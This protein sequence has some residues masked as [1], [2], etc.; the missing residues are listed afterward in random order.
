MRIDGY[1]DARSEISHH[2]P[3]SRQG[4]VA[5]DV[6]IERIGTPHSTVSQQAEQVTTRHSRSNDVKIERIGTSHTTVS[7]QAEQVRIDTGERATQKDDRSRRK[8]VCRRSQIRTE[9]RIE[10]PMNPNINSEI[11]VTLLPS[12]NGNRQWI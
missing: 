10:S 5:N 1:D 7:Q 2:C 6:E 3:K 9:L 11:Q 8:I 12:H 4:T